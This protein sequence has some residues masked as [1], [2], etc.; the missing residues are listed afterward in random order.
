MTSKPDTSQSHALLGLHVYMTVI[1]FQ[2]LCIFVFLAL[3][4]RFHMAVRHESNNSKVLQ[5]LYIQ[6]MILFLITERILFR[7]IEYRAGFKSTI[8]NHEVYQYTLDLVPMAICLMVLTCVIRDASWLGKKEIYRTG[9]RRRRG[10]S[11]VFRCAEART[12]R[13]LCMSMCRMDIS[14]C[15]ITAHIK[16]GEYRWLAC[17]VMGCD[18]EKCQNYEKGIWSQIFNSWSE[19]F[20]S[21]R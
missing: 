2:Q 9:S 11:R 8:P 7:L 19:V 13:C 1:G 4:I 5:L 16:M 21:G 12:L 17:G 3:A 15:L 18:L 10:S 14:T 20:F 6:Y